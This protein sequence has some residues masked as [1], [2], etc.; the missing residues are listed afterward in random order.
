MRMPAC[1]YMP[2]AD[3]VVLVRSA[4]GC[5]VGEVAADRGHQATLAIRRREPRQATRVTNT[6]VYGGD[7]SNSGRVVFVTPGNA[8]QKEM[9]VAHVQGGS[10]TL[11]PR[12]AVTA[13]E[14][15]ALLGPVNMTGSPPSGIRL[16]DRPQVDV[17]RKVPKLAS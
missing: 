16:T 11:I 10:E 8:A 9:F 15:I 14:I 1:P 6:T 17:Q 2:L 7:M 12:L 13:T 3:R 5:A 4:C